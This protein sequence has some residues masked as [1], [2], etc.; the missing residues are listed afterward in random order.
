MTNKNSHPIVS[1]FSLA[2]GRQRSAIRE[3]FEYGKTKAREIGNEY[4]FDFSIGNPSVPPPHQV[5][6]AFSSLLAE[7]DPIALHG[8][9]SA[10]GDFEVRKAIAAQ[11]NLEYGTSF[12]E[13]SLYISCGAAAALST[14]FRALS[15]SGEANEFITLAPYFPE[16]KC[17][18]EGHGAKLVIIP[19]KLPDFGISLEAI[20][21]AI[22]AATRAI[23][24]NSPNNPTGRVY[25]KEELE[26]LAALLRKKS[27]AIGHPL[28]IVS[29]EPYRELVYDGIV[30]PFIPL[31]YENTIICYSYSKVFSMPGE[32]IGYILVN[33]RAEAARDIYDAIAGSARSLGYVCAPSL[34]QRV[35]AR[36]VNTRPNLEPY[37]LNRKTMYEGLTAVGYECVRPEGAFYMFV[38]APGGDAQAFSD[39]ARLRYNLLVVPSESFGCPGYLRLSYCVSL[40]RIKSSLPLFDMCLKSFNS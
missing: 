9:T 14:T 6:E 34:I 27:A 37:D 3:L 22:T 2:Y 16:Y 12:D 18:V 40:E 33:P 39:H 10:P 15:I 26:A 24:L 35:I 1:D 30:T 5:D 11:L 25:K 13:S 28:F 21:R 36:C 38:K 23:I 20:D 32:R 4:I 7:C 29:D 8:Y 19:P 31:I 17:F